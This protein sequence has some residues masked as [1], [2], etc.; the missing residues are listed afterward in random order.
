M[1]AYPCAVTQWLAIA[2]LI[3]K[4]NQMPDR[5]QCPTHLGLPK[6]ASV[7][8]IAKDDPVSA[9]AAICGQRYLHEHAGSLGVGIDLHASAE[10][11]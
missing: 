11:P 1:K 6:L 10:L 9:F 4:R 3:E 2:F 7:E 8:L 5:K